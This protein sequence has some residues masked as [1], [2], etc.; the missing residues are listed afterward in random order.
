MNILILAAG[1]GKRFSDE[2]YSKPKPLINFCGKPI[3]FWLIDN[4]NYKNDDQFVVVYN[5]KLDKYRFVDL[6]KKRYPKLDIKFKSLDSITRGPAETAAIAVD[7]LDRKNDATII[8]D[9][10]NFYKTDILESARKSDSNLIY[11]FKDTQSKPLF[12]YIK[13]KEN[14]DVVIDIKEKN[15]ISDNA[16]T[17]A[18]FFIN[19][20]VLQKYAKYTIDNLNVNREIYI[21][22][23]YKQMLIDSHIIKSCLVDDYICLGTPAQLRYQSQNI[24]NY[25]N[26]I[27]CFDLDNTLV[28]YPRIAGDYSTV[29]PLQNN[30]DF[31]NLMY[32]MGYKIVIHTARRM[33]TCCGNV[34]KVRE[35]VEEITVS[36]LKEFG[37]KYHDLIF[38]KPHADFYID[39][40]AV[41]SCEDLNKEIGFYNIYDKE[42]A[43][44]KI[45]ILGNKIHKI[46]NN[47]G[48]CY[49][50]KNI[51]ND[52]KH[53]FPAT[54]VDG[55]NIIMEKIEGIPYSYM[56]VND[57]LTIKDID[58]IISDL[59]KIHSKSEQQNNIN[60][61]N[62]YCNKLK[63]RYE[64]Y[65][66]SF[67]KNSYNHYLKISH[68]LLMYENLDQG[69]KTRIHGD[70]VFT[71][72]F[73]TLTGENKFI[74]MRGKVGDVYT[75]YGDKF[76]DYAKVYQSLCGYDFIIKDKISTKTS[77]DIK[78]YFEDCFIKSFGAEKFKYLKTLTSSLLFSLI[79][80]HT[81]QDKK[82]KYLAL[83]E[84]LI[85]D[86]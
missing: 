64:S 18:Y 55:N 3:I 57:L 4:L 8:L 26:L 82:I 43:V 1:A 5:N 73:K 46:T 40:L 39:D 29:N 80:L 23:V 11:Y 32:D 31:C 37:V 47:F 79:P 34:E 12:S 86:L 81:E 42:R 67:Y 20:N 25:D 61:Y 9:C 44:N 74:D 69:E 56:F 22:D 50:Y 65:D 38:G 75:I 68:G 63:N 71:N 45:L 54:Q 15:K 70:P 52:I 28:T 19:A 2:G 85:A 48:E 33:K 21:S 72:I 17:G 62:N 30:I 7:M 10:D 36:K 6:I 77:E 49:W 76:Y 13:L 27:F 60:I 24:K 51:P 41:N 53:L 84:K 16:N 78:K 58:S 66:Y 14:S 59:Q 35:Q 83:S